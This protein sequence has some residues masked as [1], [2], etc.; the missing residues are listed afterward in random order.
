MVLI[1]F[2]KRSSWYVSTMGLFHWYETEM[3]IVKM[4]HV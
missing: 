3:M 2:N 1:K 4:S